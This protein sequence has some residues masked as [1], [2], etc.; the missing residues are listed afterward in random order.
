MYKDI[1]SMA[2]QGMRKTEEIAQ[3]DVRDI[4]GLLRTRIKLRKEERHN[5]HILRCTSVAQEQTDV[6]RKDFTGVHSGD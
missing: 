3:I 5:L 1:I 6:P 4:T 2:L